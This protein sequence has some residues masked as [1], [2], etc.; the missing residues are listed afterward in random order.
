MWKLSAWIT[1]TPRRFVS[2][3]IFNC[4]LKHFVHFLE[5]RY[6]SVCLVR[7]VDVS[8]AQGRRIAG[9]GDAL[10]QAK[11]SQKE[12]PMSLAHFM[13]ARLSHHA[14]RTMQVVDSD[15]TVTPHVR[16]IIVYAGE[17]NT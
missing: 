16:A 15:S 4:S 11:S 9:L 2:I 17:G 1:E 12:R 5:Y 13:K 3:A 6:K 7:D 8:G 14:R 10:F